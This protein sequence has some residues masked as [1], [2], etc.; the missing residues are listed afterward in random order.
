MGRCMGEKSLAKQSIEQAVEQAAE[1]QRWRMTVADK[2]D[3]HGHF[4]ESVNF[5]DCGKTFGNFQMVVCEDD[6]THD[7]R[8]LPFTCQQRICP[9]CERR[10]SAELVAKYTPILKDISEMPDRPL[11]SLKKIML[12]T[13]YALSAESAPGDYITAWEGFERFQQLL[14]QDLLGDEMTRAEKRRGRIDYTAHGYGSLVAA[15]FGEQGRKLHFHILAFLPFVNKRRLTDLWLQAT[16]GECMV[17]WIGRVDYHDVDDQVREQVKYITK[18]G[19]LPPDDVIK[20]RDVLDGTRRLRTYGTVRGAIADEPA[21]HVCAVCA[22]KM[23][24]MRVREYFIAV[25]LRN[26]APDESILAA[27]RSIYLDLIPV[28]KAGE[29]IE[30]KARD[31]PDPLPIDQELPFLDAIAPKKRP[32]QYF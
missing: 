5:R 11:W 20:L 18:F 8:A 27:A 28:N 9:D 30:H 12:S 7:C 32:F 22:G 24:L 6:P 25:I 16:D 10:R 17:T 3:D 26:V 14:L 31:D 23:T 19:D 4:S 21:P 2:L 13:P 15:E 29:R 1:Y